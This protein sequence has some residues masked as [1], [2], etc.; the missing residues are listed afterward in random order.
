M[1]KGIIQQVV[2]VLHPGA[3]GLI[4]NHHGHAR[5]KEACELVDLAKAFLAGSENTTPIIA[6]PAVGVV[7]DV[8][9]RLLD[10]EEHAGEAAIPAV[11]ADAADMIT[12]LS[13]AL[14]AT[15]T[16]RS[17]A[18]QYSEV[19][20]R[21][22]QQVAGVGIWDYDDLN[23]I[24]RPT[25]GF[26]DSHCTLMELV[27]EARGL[28]TPLIAPDASLD[29][30]LRSLDVVDD[31]LNQ[32]GFKPDGSARNVLSIARSYISRHTV[33]KIVRPDVKLSNGTIIRHT[34]LVN[35]ATSAEQLGF[36]AM[37]HAE[38]AEYSVLTAPDGGNCRELASVSA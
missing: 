14:H 1:Q 11:A 37:S 25:E 3:V 26:L 27:N 19:A 9:V 21:F 4:G 5:C 36:G 16:A 35:G 7:H 34:R 12:R 18:M 22:V 20:G 30:A 29:H 31:L 38:F 23:E 10:S 33:D 17:G 6:A 2:H 32:A 15:Q 8:C 13:T 24:V 28:V